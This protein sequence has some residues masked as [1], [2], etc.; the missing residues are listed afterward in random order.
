MASP[1]NPRGL[2]LRPY[3]E[4]AVQAIQDA[5]REGISRPLVALPTGTGKTLIFSSLIA[6]R[7]GRSLVLAHRDELIQ[8][9]RDKLLVS[10]DFQLGIVKAAANEVTA[11]VVVASIQTLSRPSRLEQLAGGFNTIVVDEAHHAVADSYQRILEHL[12]CFE[13]GGPLTLGCTATPQRGDGVG[14]G[15]VW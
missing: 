1:A 6:R 2:P 15:Q 4:A 8:Q 13:A 11:P 7:P 9:A 14:L 10:P 3:Q 5:E 12:G